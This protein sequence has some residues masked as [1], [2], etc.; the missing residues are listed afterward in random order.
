MNEPSKDI[1]IIPISKFQDNFDDYMEKIEIS[2][3]SFIIET[4]N[5]SQAVMVPADEEIIKIHTECNN[6]AS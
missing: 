6:D 2:K 4:E 1:E 3:K 5:G